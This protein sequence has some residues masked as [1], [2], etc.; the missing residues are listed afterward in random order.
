[1]HSPN[2]LRDLARKCRERA[3]SATDPAI[4]EQLCDWA[5]ELTDAADVAE[6]NLNNPR[7]PDIVRT[8][9]ERHSV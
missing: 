9:F 2:E 7:D 4:V 3:N 5:V 8:L 1:M 6:W